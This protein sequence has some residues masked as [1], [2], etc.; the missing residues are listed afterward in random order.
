MFNNKERITRTASDKEE[1]KLLESMKKS[2]DKE[3]KEEE[4]EMVDMSRGGNPH[5][6]EIEMERE[7]KARGDADM[8]TQQ[9]RETKTNA[10]GFPFFTL[11]H[12][13]LWAQIGVLA[14][15]WIDAGVNSSCWEYVVLDT[16]VQESKPSCSR[17]EDEMR[18][19]LGIMVANILG[20]FIM[21]FLTENKAH[22]LWFEAPTMPVSFL[23]ENNFIQYYQE[24]LTGLRVGF[25]GSLTTFASWGFQMVSILTSGRLG[26]VLLVLLLEISVSLVAFV[27]GEQ[28]ALRIHMMVV[29][30]HDTHKD[31]RIKLWH[32]IK[33]NKI[34][35]S[36][37]PAHQP[38]ADDDGG[39]SVIECEDGDE[40]WLVR[41]RPN[42]TSGSGNTPAEKYRVTD[43]VIIESPNLARKA[44]SV[45]NVASSSD[46]SEVAYPSSMARVEKEM[47]TQKRSKKPT[48]QQVKYIRNLNIIFTLALIAFTVLWSC[49]VKF[50]GNFTRR[51][52]WL[53]LLFAPFGCFL[54]WHMC[55][56]YNAGV[57]K[58]RLGWFPVGTFSINVGAT[59]MNSVASA[60]TR[61]LC[62]SATNLYWL[63]VTLAAFQTGFDGALSTV[64][65]FVSEVHKYM[66]E[67]P[68][69]YKGWLYLVSSFVA[70]ILLGFCFYSWSVFTSTVCEAN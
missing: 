11:V 58:G 68:R 28:L 66:L 63:A 51:K 65:T 69:N 26:A 56:D 36:M 16:Q 2:E 48:R 33:K 43:L 57:L 41:D 49:L 25:C 38:R 3:D 13:A 17:P 31:R 46:P 1:Q 14:R 62:A 67:Y 10:K 23:P 20:S 55:M 12:L 18:D 29:G 45:R 8:T 50:D 35:A 6:M 53:S 19:V 59:V 15:F 64:S 40:V 39:I 44:L 60:V 5:G 47:S 9:T 30:I 54:R 7:G 70:A 32:Q 27:L 34:F 22:L 21:G 37:T 52:C 42:T 24:L 61:H 4:T